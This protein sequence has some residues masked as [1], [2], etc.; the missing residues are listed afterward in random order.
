MQLLARAELSL[1]R[2]PEATFDLAV[3]NG[4]LPRVLLAS[5]PLPGIVSVTYEDGGSARAGARRTAK[6]TDKSEL[7]EEVLV[8]DRP[9]E[10]TYRWAEPPPVVRPLLR[11]ATAT[12]TFTPEGNGTRIRWTYVFDLTTPLVYVPARVFTALFQRWMQQGLDRM[13]TLA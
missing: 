3:A 11:R 7:V 13:T 10:H 12:W 6:M 9:R 5:F 1:P 8:N 2:S 4:T